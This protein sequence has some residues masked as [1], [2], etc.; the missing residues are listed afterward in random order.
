[1][2][3]M[4]KSVQF[5]LCLS[6][7][8]IFLAGMGVS[9]QASVSSNSGVILVKFKPGTDTVSERAAVAQAG[10]S[11]IAS[12]PQL[13]IKKVTI[14]KGS[15]VDE[16]LARYKRD[17]RVEYAEQPHVYKAL[18]T[19]NDPYLANQWNLAKISAQNG[20]N[21][22]IGNPGAMIAVIDTGVSPTHPDLAGKLTGG[23]NAITGTGNYSDDNGHGTHVAG[24]AAAATN[25]NLGIAGV[26]WNCLVMPIKA[27]DNT[28]SGYDYDIAVGIKYA[29]DSG[30]K[31]INM[32]FGSLDQSYSIETAVD[33]AYGKG[34][35]I[36]AATGN[37][38]AASIFYPAVLNHVIS[39]GATNASDTRASFSNFGTGLDVVAPGTDIWSTYWDTATN[40]NTYTQLNGTSMASPEV[41]GLAAL[42]FTQNPGWGPDQIATQIENTADDL[43]AAGPDTMYGNG[44]INMDKALSGGSNIPTITSH[45]NGMLIKGASTATVYLLENKSKRPI[46]S[47]NV[48]MS[49]GFR[50]DRIVTIGDTELVSYT[51]G[52]A[53]QARPGTLIKGSSPAVYITDY[54]QGVYFKSLI[55]SADIFTAL[56]LHWEDIVTLTDAEVGNYTDLGAITT[57]DTHPDGLLVKTASSAAVYYIQDNT[58][59]AITSATI[60]NADCLRWDRINT[61]SDAEMNGY[62]APGLELMA[63][64]GT[65]IKGTSAAVYIT[66]YSGGTGGTYSKR[67]ISSA[68]MFTALG[69]H[70]EDIYQISDDEVSR[71]TTGTPL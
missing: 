39:V 12:I 24:I 47:A 49:Y 23:Y 69:L 36:V 41:A 59:H 20:W 37:T 35:V 17:P 21:Y 44:R 25:N 15:T 19:P 7:L 29:A 13:G 57:A 52:Q 71:Y 43:G 26:G 2:S 10:G 30:A 46:I 31:V 58:R 63:R 34:C 14:P 18:M 6:A 16:E 9:A 61:I 51:T 4:K 54:T 1:M 27:L 38:G 53:L 28:G 33:Y 67:A 66:D 40:S 45:A 8:C 48:F 5:S 42:L 3:R 68:L 60:F 70:W 11:E 50:W 32:S 65:L 55:N 64:P 56:G 22:T 62:G